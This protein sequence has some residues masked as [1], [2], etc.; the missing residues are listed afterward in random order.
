MKSDS[1]I[2]LLC[3]YDLNNFERKLCV[4]DIHVTYLWSMNSVAIQQIKEKLAHL[5]H[6]QPCILR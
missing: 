5:P 3:Q 1:S 6:L 4:T 2:M